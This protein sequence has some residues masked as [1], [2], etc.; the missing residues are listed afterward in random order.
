MNKEE[1]GAFYDKLAEL[2]EHG[3]EGDVRTYVDHYY[4]RLP[5]TVRNEILFG[6]LADAVHDLAREEA[7]VEQVIEEGL[8]AAEALQQAKEQIQRSQ[9][10]GLT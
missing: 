8:S 6:A 1:L 4:P 3:T 2:T 5:E 9:K 10:N 7:A